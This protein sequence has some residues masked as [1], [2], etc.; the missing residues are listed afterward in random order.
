MVVMAAAVVMVM[1]V[2]LVVVMMML[3]LVFIVIIVIIVVMVMVMAAAAFVLVIIVMV[4]MVLVFILVVVLGASALRCSSSAD[5]VSRRSIVSRICLPSSSVHGVVTIVAVGFFSR[6]S[7][8]AASSFSGR[9]PSVRE[10]MMA[11]AFSTWLLKNSP[12]F[13][14]YILHLFAST[15]VVKPLST[16]SSDCTPCTA[17]MTSLSL[18]TPEGSMRMRSG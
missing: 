8:T 5:S 4:V 10:R 17:R 3:V 16:S 1:L 15:T 18:P 9:I 14:M 12:K 7:A 11:L 6:S 13:F 2:M